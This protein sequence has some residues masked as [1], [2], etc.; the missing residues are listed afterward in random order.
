MS[1]RKHAMLAVCG[2][3][4]AVQCRAAREHTDARPICVRGRWGSLGCL[5]PSLRG[6]APGSG[7]DK[8]SCYARD[9]HTRTAPARHQLRLT[10]L[11]AAGTHCRRRYRALQ[12][13]DGGACCPASGRWISRCGVRPH[14]CQ[15]VCSHTPSSVDGV[16]EELGYAII[17]I[18]AKS[19]S[20]ML[21]LRA[22]DK[23]LKTRVRVTICYCNVL[24]LWIDLC[25]V[26][27]L[28]WGLLSTHLLAHSVCARYPGSSAGI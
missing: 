11:A 5:C 20:I 9:T 14:L 19:Y 7:A 27:A 10:S 17:Q 22:T 2:L 4:L 25:G 13:R 28:G 8:V 21:I 24:R 15:G 3:A 6:G 12:E 16:D 23:M 26:P 1:H 18:C